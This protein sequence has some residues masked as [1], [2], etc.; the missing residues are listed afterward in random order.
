MAKPPV[1]LKDGRTLRYADLPDDWTEFAA[2]E[3]DFPTLCEEETRRYPEFEEELVEYMQREGEEIDRDSLTFLRSAR[4][5]EWRYW[6]WEVELPE[7]DK[8]YA[9]ASEGSSQQRLSYDQD[10]NGLTPE[11]FLLA[12]HFDCL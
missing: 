2:L 1:A 4:L 10:W 7:G 12:T 5:N 3:V 8:G 11:Q 9:T 6:I